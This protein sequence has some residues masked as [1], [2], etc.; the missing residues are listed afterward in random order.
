MRVSFARG[1]LFAGLCSRENKG[2]QRVTRV[3]IPVGDDP[4]WRTFFGVM[5]DGIRKDATFRASPYVETPSELWSARLGKSRVESSRPVYSSIS[6]LGHMFF[7]CFSR[8]LPICPECSFL[9]PCSLY[10]QSFEKQPWPGQ[11]LYLEADVCFRFPDKRS[12]ETPGA[13]GSPG[14]APGRAGAAEGEYRTRPRRGAVCLGRFFHNGLGTQRTGRFSFTGHFLIKSATCFF[15]AATSLSLPKLVCCFMTMFLGAAS[16]WMFLF[17]SGQRPC[18]PVTDDWF[19]KCPPPPTFRPL[20]PPRIAV[21]DALAPGRVAGP[22]AEAS[23][24]RPAG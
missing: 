7:F 5:F 1:V 14:S 17:H 6:V 22:A 12:L 24:K 23:G 9:F 19:A 4:K 3:Q 10:L 18:W 16:C 2:S 15:L 8:N 21:R 20:L 11:F 13:P